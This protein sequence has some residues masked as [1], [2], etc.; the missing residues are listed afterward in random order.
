MKHVGLDV[1]VEW[2]IDG[3]LLAAIALLIV[4]VGPNRIFKE[5]RIHLY[6]PLPPR[7]FWVF[8]KGEF[9]GYI[10]GC[11]TGP[12]ALFFIVPLLEYTQ[13]DD[14]FIALLASGYLFASWGVIPYLIERRIDHWY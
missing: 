2:Y 5:S 13:A 14:T 8:S 9:I 1:L 12:L 6:G 10:L 11:I 4:R 7:F 3:I